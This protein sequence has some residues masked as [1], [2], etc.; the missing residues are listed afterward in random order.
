MVKKKI[1][2]V[3]F[4]T[5]EDKRPFDKLLY[6]V[7]ILGMLNGMSLLLAV[8]KLLDRKY[9][10]CAIFLFLFYWTVPPLKKK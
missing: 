9:I 1:E 8:L 4:Q 10:S 5:E 3:Q 7:H 2:E 6:K